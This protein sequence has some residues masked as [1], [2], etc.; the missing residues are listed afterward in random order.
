MALQ[1]AKPQ[2]PNEAG[3]AAR[4]PRDRPQ[5]RGLCRAGGIA[6]RFQGVRISG[7]RGSQDAPPL[8]PL[9]LGLLLLAALPGHCLADSGKHLGGGSVSTAESTAA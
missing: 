4:E 7:A 6:A 1:E 2:G 8:R 5:E 9:L 3:P